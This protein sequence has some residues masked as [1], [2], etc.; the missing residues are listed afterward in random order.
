MKYLIV[1]FTIVFCS[2]AFAQ[3][4]EY[5]RGFNAG[6]KA[7][8]ADGDGKGMQTH[9]FDPTTSTQFPDF[10]RPNILPDFDTIDDGRFPSF[11]NGVL[12]SPGALPLKID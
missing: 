9:D 2:T 1:L 8:F 3:T 6:Y 7:G 11:G 12:D 5:D 4:S 10:I